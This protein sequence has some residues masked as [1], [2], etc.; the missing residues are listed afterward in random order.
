MSLPV[1]V[2]TVRWLTGLSRLFASCELV[3]CSQ[4]DVELA[5]SA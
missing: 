2:S 4:G 3:L 1:D 5:G